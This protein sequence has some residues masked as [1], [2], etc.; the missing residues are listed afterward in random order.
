MNY[1]IKLE[2]QASNRKS[3]YPGVEK[4][5]TPE[6]LS[7]IHFYGIVYKIYKPFSLR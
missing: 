1:D 2:I 3:I 6:Q 7:N 4:T 5:N